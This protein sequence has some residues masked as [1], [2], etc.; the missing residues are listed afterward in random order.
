MEKMSLE[1]AK[2]Q[3]AGQWLAFLVIEETPSGELWG[4]V[5]AHNHDR[6]ELH[7]ELRGKK[8]DRAYVTF[9]GPVVKPGYAVIL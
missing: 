2:Q 8:V 9:A 5:I 1:K 3:Y 6:R 7:Q 4:E